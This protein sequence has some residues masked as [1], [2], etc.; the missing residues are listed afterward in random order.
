MTTIRMLF[1]LAQFM[2]VLAL[3]DS[4]TDAT[5]VEE[6]ITELLSGS[7]NGVYFV[8]WC[9]ILVIDAKVLIQI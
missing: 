9:V 8:N 1:L 2:A 3:F 4:L 5:R 7:I 6:P